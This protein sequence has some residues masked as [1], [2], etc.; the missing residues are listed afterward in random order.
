MIMTKASRWSRGLCE[1]VSRELQ[2]VSTSTL[3]TRGSDDKHE[4]QLSRM[5]A[6]WC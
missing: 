6:L 4:R 2:E 5:S 3:L 1:R